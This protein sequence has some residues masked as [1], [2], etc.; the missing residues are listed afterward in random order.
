MCPA[1]SLLFISFNTHT[2]YTVESLLNKMNSPNEV[3]SQRLETKLILVGASVDQ[4]C[5]YLFSPH[6]SGFEAIRTL[7]S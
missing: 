3:N 1:V 4:S 7:R 5:I 2:L 6:Q